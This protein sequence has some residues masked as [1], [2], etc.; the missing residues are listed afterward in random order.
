MKFSILIPV[1]NAE[2]YI[3]DCINSIKKQTFEDWECIIIDDGS[4]DDTYKV[5][6]DNVF[7]DKRFIVKQQLNQGVAKTRNELLK[8]AKGDYI[9]WIDA[10]DFISETTLHIL[11]KNIS[12]YN[13]DFLIF[14]YNLVYENLVSTVRLLNRNNCII[15]KKDMFKYLAQEY[16]MPSFLWNK[17]ISKKLYEGISF[18]SNLKMLEDYNELCELVYKSQKI[19]YLNNCLYYYRQIESSIT[20]NIREDILYQNLKVREKRESFIL[21][22]FPSLINYIKSGKAYIS[23][24]Y[25]VV[26]ANSN[27]KTLFEIFKRELRKNI[28]YYILSKDI[29]FKHKLAGVLIAINFRIY[30]S[31]KNILKIFK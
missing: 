14:N 5:I 30:S 22:K 2:Q 7:D 6:L 15:E 29:K 17:V 31:I 4:K 12:K 1:Y 9:V 20:H 16:N 13:S 3:V 19:L 25:I 23:I 10:D 18:D 28:L 11:N 24:N 27:Y 8:I 26:S 21:K